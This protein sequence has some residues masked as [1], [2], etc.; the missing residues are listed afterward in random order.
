MYS[1]LKDPTLFLLRLPQVSIIDVQSLQHYSKSCSFFS[2]PHQHSVQVVKKKKPNNLYFLFTGSFS[3]AC[4][5][6][7]R[8]I[9]YQFFSVTVVSTCKILVSWQT[10]VSCFT[11]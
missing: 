7:E 8:S 10:Y 6:N 9:K 1:L 3:S 4:C 5:G 11:G 2:P